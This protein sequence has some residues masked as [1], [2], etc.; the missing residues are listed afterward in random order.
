VAFNGVRNLSWVPTLYSESFF[1]KIINFVLVICDLLYDSV[2]ISDT[3]IWHRLV[4]WSAQNELES[5]CRE[6]KVVY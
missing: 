4:E 3:S 2:N 6:A 5:N 1:R